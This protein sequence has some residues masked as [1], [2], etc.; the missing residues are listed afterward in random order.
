MAKRA[1]GEQ[2]R[3]DKR[4]RKRARAFVF[5]VGRHV[6]RFLAETASTLL[7][8]PDISDEELAV[9]FLSVGFR[10]QILVGLSAKE[11]RDTVKKLWTN[12]SDQLIITRMRTFLRNLPKDFLCHG[13][14]TNHSSFSYVNAWIVSCVLRKSAAISDHPPRDGVPAADTRE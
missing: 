13:L 7:Q 14:P 1:P 10:K 2:V 11:M 4:P 3:V 12:A 5:N 6:F 8:D 9:T